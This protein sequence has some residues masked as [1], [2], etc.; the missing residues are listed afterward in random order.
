MSQ[1]F[2]EQRM[3]KDWKTKAPKRKPRVIRS[4][5]WLAQRVLLGICIGLMM[6]GARFAYT[7]IP[8]FAQFVAEWIAL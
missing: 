1:N 8:A 3:L 2:T 7:E 4:I 6:L 5:E